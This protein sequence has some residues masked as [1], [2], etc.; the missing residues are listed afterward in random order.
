MWIVC[1]FKT[2]THGNEVLDNTRNKMT[3]IYDIHSVIK[4]EFNLTLT[5]LSEL[6]FQRLI[7]RY[8][9]FYN[10][11]FIYYSS[12]HYPSNVILFMLRCW[13]TGFSSFLHLVTL[14]PEVYYTFRGSNF[15]WYGHYNP[16][17]S[18]D[19]KWFSMLV[20]YSDKRVASII[21]IDPFLD[22]ICWN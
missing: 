10:Y 2:V 9:I 15:V 3:I 7:N 1:N 21:I 12:I 11:N 19:G 4:Q 17:V 6:S 8:N 13:L 18:D 20:W 16:W 14:L 5:T 22:V